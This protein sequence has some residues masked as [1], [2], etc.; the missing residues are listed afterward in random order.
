MK[1]GDVSKAPPG[2]I[3]D[4]VSAPTAKA[5]QTA[6]PADA[7]FLLGIPEKELTPAVNRALT[8]LLDDLHTLRQELEKAHALRAEFERLADR[9]PL[10]DILNRRAFVSEL[11]RGLGMIERYGVR[12]SL[13][14]LDLDNLKQIND[15]KGHAAGDKALTAVASILAEN[16]RQTDT[17]GRLGGD[18][19]GVILFQSSQQQAASKAK[20]LSD[21]INAE[22]IDWNGE[23]FSISVSWGAAEL[24]D[25]SSVEEIMN[26]ADHE[27]YKFKMEKSLKR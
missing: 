5:V 14:F 9:D 13:I 18:E 4:G 1:I 23:R 27:M 11:N 17:V 12:S 8:A 21:L 3:R 2:K 10:L 15:T 16:I 24:S 25:G 20:E 6:S 7:V 19:F 22:L 26:S